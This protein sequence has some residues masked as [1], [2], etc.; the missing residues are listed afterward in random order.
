LKH[1][2]SNTNARVEIKGKGSRQPPEEPG[3]DDNLHIVV[4]CRFDAEFNKAVKLV[5]D[6]VDMVRKVYEEH[7]VIVG[8]RCGA[9]V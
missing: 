5:E 3:S 6:L 4:S 8:S 2:T 1:I 7:K 9:E